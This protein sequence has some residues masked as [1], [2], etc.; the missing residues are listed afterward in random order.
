MKLF[1]FEYWV[2]ALLFVLGGAAVLKAGGSDGA[3]TLNH[4]RTSTKSAEQRTARVIPRIPVEKYKLSNGLE[5]LLSEE[6]HSPTVAVNLSYRVGPVNE[7]RECTG[8]AHLFEHM[9]FQGSRHVGANQ[10]F[11]YLEAAGGSEISAFTGFERTVYYETVPSNQLELALW[12]ESDRMGYLP[13]RLDQNELITQQAVVRNER[14]QSYENKPYGLSETTVYHLLFPESHPYFGAV[15]GSHADIQRAKLEDIRKFFEMYYAPNRASLV[16]VGD[17]QTARV[18]QLVQK[19]FGP[20]RRGSDLPK[21]DVRTPPITSERRTVVKEHIQLPRVYMTWITPPIFEPGDAEADIASVILLGSKY[22]GFASSRLNKKLVQ[23]KKIAQTGWATYSQLGLGSVFQI[24]AT[25]LPGHTAEEIEKG[26]SEE[27]ERFR[28]DGPEEKELERARN[29]IETQVNAA[30]QSASFR[31][32]ELNTY[33]HYRRSPDYLAEGLL[34]YRRAT[35]ASV[36]EF[37]QHYLGPESRVV[38]LSVPGEPDFGPEVPTPPKGDTNAAG[39]GAESIN[40]DQLWRAQPPKPGPPAR[41]TLPVPRSFALANGFTV[42][43]DERPGLPIAAA[44]VVRSGDES[45]PPGKPGLAFLTANMLD[46]G[47]RTRSAFQIADDIAQLGATAYP[48]A[49]ID[50][51]YV[52]LTPLLK[53]NFAAALS[54]VADMVLHPSFPAEELEQKRAIW[55]G[56]ILRQRADPRFLTANVLSLV[57][58]GENHPYGLPE[59]GTEPALREFTQDDLRAFWTHNFHPG[60]AALIVSGGITE[61]ELRALAKEKFGT[62]QQSSAPATPSLLTTPTTAC[63]VVIVDRPGA[64]QTSLLIGTLGPPRSTPDYPAL[65]VMNAELGGLFSSRIGLN[66]REEHGYTYGVRSGFAYFHGGGRFSAA[67]E[68]R[69]EVTAPAVLEVFNELRRI[70]NTSMTSEELHLAR[71]SK[72]SSLPAE[73]ESTQGAVSKFVDLYLY[74]LGLDYYA[75]LPARLNVVSADE[76]QRVAQKYLVPEEMIVVAVG[77][78]A[79]IEPEMRKLNLGPVEIRDVTGKVQQ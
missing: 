75:K 39:V 67:T 53:K 22:C 70:R 51:S 31:A 76:A 23:E 58:Y 24:T 68:V 54:I 29:I 79:K 66:L 55:L 52:H 40:S 3:L 15:I 77:D 59:I 62:W 35:T 4:S 7:Q 8:F 5:V 42:I 6:H 34:R 47:T 25:A 57:L 64:P 26:M 71:G 74:D 13:D 20:L 21:I 14:R 1:A 10:H 11:R 18:K 32:L 60:N 45:N 28:L 30:R 56:Q 16:I 69:T 44:L 36:R 38:V 9:M 46:Q 49:S 73:F 27:L 43:Y 17:F 33:N 19:Y 48:F 12:L 50:T 65:E 78:R 2:A 72:V 61:A 37:A 41:F 63:R